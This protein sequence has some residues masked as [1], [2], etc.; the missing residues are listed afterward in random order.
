MFEI[1]RTNSSAAASKRP[2]PSS[3]ASPSSPSLPKRSKSVKKVSWWDQMW[4]KD[5][6]P[7]PAGSGAR[8]CDPQLTGGKG[9]SQMKPGMHVLKD[10]KDLEECMTEWVICENSRGYKSF[11]FICPCKATFHIVLAG[12][13]LYYKRG[14]RIRHTEFPGKLRVKFLYAD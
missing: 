9:T 5:L 4:E 6:R 1:R 3:P 12:K 14:V 2:A 11:E 7:E 10:S 8:S 13:A